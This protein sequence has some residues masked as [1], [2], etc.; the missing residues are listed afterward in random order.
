MARFFLMLDGVRILTLDDLK[1]HFKPLD[2]LDR[3]RSGALQRWLAE[4]R[5]DD[6]LH[7]IDAIDKSSSDETAIRALNEVFGV[8]DNCEK[9]LS[10]LDDALC[11]AESD[12]DMLNLFEG[13]NGQRNLARLDTLANEGNVNAQNQLALMYTKGI[14]VSKD[15]VKFFTTLPEILYQKA[16]N[17]LKTPAKSCDRKQ[18]VLCL[19]KAAELGHVEACHLLGSIYQRGF[20]DG[21]PDNVSAMKWFQKA[22]ERG[23]TKSS[24]C[25]RKLL[26]LRKCIFSQACCVEHGCVDVGGWLAYCYI[27]GLGVEQ[28]YTKALMF[29]SMAA[30]KGCPIGVKMLGT[31]FDEC[32]ITKGIHEAETWTKE[33]AWR[34]KLALDAEIKQVATG[35]AKESSAEADALYEEACRSQNVQ[36]ALQY[37]EKA[38]E[39]GHVDVC[40][41]LGRLYLDGSSDVEKNSATAAKWFRLA[42][43]RGSAEGQ[44]HLGECFYYGNGVEEDKIEAV[45]WFQLAAERHYAEA[46]NK[47]GCCY[48]NGDGVEENTEKAAQSSCQCNTSPISPG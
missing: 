45:K 10:A 44:F 5:L 29:A 40:N 8:A 41:Q 25:L 38:A 16:L 9:I 6:M 23:S 32:G 7:K 42:A 26:H 14:G 17:Y 36:E 47:L 24:F 13:T 46:L 19:E 30:E 22:A 27:F 48:Q 1:A 35:E 21:E 2:A 39:L 33:E 11:H 31:G 18:A 15:Q 37:A 43:E 12:E 4:Q 28:D 3:F 34:Y 20:G